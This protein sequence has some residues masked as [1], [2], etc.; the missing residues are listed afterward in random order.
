MSGVKEPV[1]V[2]GGKLVLPW[3]EEVVALRRRA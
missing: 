3:H 2:S 1:A